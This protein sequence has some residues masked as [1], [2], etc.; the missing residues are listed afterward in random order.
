MLQE[1]S[2]TRVVE[3]LKNISLSSVPPWLG[4]QVATASRYE[5]SLAVGYLS[6]NVTGGTE[7]EQLLLTAA[8]ILHDVGNGPFPHI[9]DQVMKETL[10]ITHEH[11]VK[12]AFQYS[13]IEDKSALERYGLNLNEVS[14]ILENRHNLSPFF[15]G[16]PDLDNA[17]NI[18]RFLTTIPGNP[19]GPASYQPVEIASSMSL[20][21]KGHDLSNN[22]VKRWK[23]DFQKVYTYVWND[24]ANMI[25]W[26]MLGRVLR[27]L[28]GAL[29][30]SFFRLTNEE[31]HRFVSLKVPRWGKAMK[32][33]N[34]QIVFDKKF[35]NLTGESMGMTEKS[36]LNEIEMFLCKETGLEEWMLGLT[37]DQPLLGEEPD[38]WR[39][40]LVTYK[41]NKKPVAIISDILKDSE[42]YLS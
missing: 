12:F 29:T 22:L 34:F 38:H 40:Y 36:N 10:G 32:E 15:Y 28:K 5:H 37:V 7:H 2:K 21:I 18:Y 13:V 25:C 6:L 11:A 27:I 30:P 35:K 41:G 16:F 24:S 1:L 42:P 14:M 33:S 8:A 31:A 3:R 17:D 19:L 20:D 23:A 26:T 9:S 39:V 4:P